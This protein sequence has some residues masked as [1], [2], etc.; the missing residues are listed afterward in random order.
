[1]RLIGWILLLSGAWSLW[2]ALAEKESLGMGGILIIAVGV[3]LL[4][5]RVRALVA[6]IGGGLLM[7]L[8]LM[9]GA[10]FLIIGALALL[11][12]GQVLAVGATLPVQ[13]VVVPLLFLG[14]GLVLVLVG[15]IRPVRQY[16]A[17]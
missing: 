12:Y 14:W 11:T 16:R 8:C 17:F 6:W 7:G 13:S 9:G 1:M 3:A 4:A 15:V 2:K 5:P 10:W